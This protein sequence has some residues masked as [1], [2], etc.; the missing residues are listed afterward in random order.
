VAF[1]AP[2]FGD[3]NA[4]VGMSLHP[5]ISAPLHLRYQSRLGGRRL[6][7]FQISFQAVTKS[8]MFLALGVRSPWY[9]QSL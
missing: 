3:T 2:P 6:L 9:S 5:W 1:P 8:W 7:Y 4:M